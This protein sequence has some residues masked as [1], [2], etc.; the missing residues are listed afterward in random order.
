MAPPNPPTYTH[1]LQETIRAHRLYMGLSK[2]GMAVQLKM[3]GRTYDRIES[4]DRDCP[5][6][7]ID[8]INAVVSRFDDEV[9]AWITKA[10][11]DPVKV[12]VPNDPRQ[13]WQRA[14]LGR[15]AVESPHITLLSE[16]Q[17]L[18]IR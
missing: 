12:H 8:S 10:Q 9:D 13:E 4:G 18:P 16:E 11:D 14:V 2:D 6:G 3:N 1:G 7:L 17:H 15:A 5:P